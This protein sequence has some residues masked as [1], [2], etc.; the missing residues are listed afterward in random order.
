MLIFSRFSLKFIKRILFII[1]SVSIGYFSVCY[2]YVYVLKKH[3]YPLKYRQEVFDS[4]NEFGLDKALVYALIKTESGFDKNALSDKGA[5]G[6][7]QITERTGEFIAEKLGVYVYDLKDARTNIRFGCY[8]LRYLMN[9]FENQK[10]VLC[11]YNAGEGNVSAWLANT[12]YSLDGKTLY[13]IPFRET[14]EYIVKIEKSFTKYT[15]L[16]DKILDKE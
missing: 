7:M 5:I 3:F 6:L 2:G 14:E 10:T 16:Y 1:I 13:K 15:K 9:R 12:K 8:Y 11:A 4:A